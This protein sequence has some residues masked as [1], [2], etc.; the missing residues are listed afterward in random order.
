MLFASFHGRSFSSTRNI[1]FETQLG[2]FGLNVI[3]S[4]EVTVHTLK[5]N[6]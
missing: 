3:S 1:I 5:H 4:V 6:T 2:G